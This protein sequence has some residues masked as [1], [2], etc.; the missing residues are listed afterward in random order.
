[1]KTLCKIGM[2]IGILFFYVEVQ[3]M[4]LITN[5]LVTA[6]EFSG[7]ANDSSPTGN[8]GEVFGAQLSTDRFGNANSAYYFDGDDYILASASSL[9]TAERTVSLWF[10]ADTL[11]NSYSNNNVLL[12]YGGEYQ[13]NV[14]KS[15]VMQLYQGLAYTSNLDGASYIV[16]SHWMT[17][18]L[19]YYDSQSPVGS[20]TNYAITTDSSGTKIFINGELKISNSTF[21]NNTVVAGKDL[22]IGICPDAWGNAPYTSEPG[23][24]FKGSMDDVLIYNRA[25]SANEINQLAGGLPVP[26]PS[27]MFLFVTGIAGLVGSMFRR[28]KN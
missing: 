20:W 15:W 9:P 8:N 16:Q 19:Q 28:K 18:W 5:G 27:T 3:A 22:S 10:K 4:P 6:Y 17:N 24:Y 25:L 2:V 13:W 1:M 14:G 21:I 12:G 26:E 7:N 23:V 11:S